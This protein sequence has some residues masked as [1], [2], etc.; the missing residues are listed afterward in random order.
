[1]ENKN[2]KDF[3]DKL[4]ILSKPLGALLTAFIIAGI[5][6]YG[7]NFLVKRQSEEMKIRLYTE[8]IS[9]REQAESSLRKDML[10]SII[11]SFLKPETASLEGKVLNLE[12]LA[13][14]F[15]E[16]LNLKP[17]FVHLK[18]QI[19]KDSSPDSADYMQ[20]VKKVAKEIKRKQ[21]AILEGA[22]DK[23]DINIRLEDVSS[24][25]GKVN[26]KVFCLQINNETHNEIRTYSRSFKV[27]VHSFDSIG[28]GIG[29]RLEVGPA[30]PDEC[31]EIVEETEIFEQS[32]NTLDEWEDSDEG[33]EIV[34]AE[35]T[36][37]VAQFWVDFF[38]F[39]MIDN[40]RLSYDQRCAVVLKEINEEDKILEIA[41]LYFPGSHASLKEKPYYD[42]IVNKLLSAGLDKNRNK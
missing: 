8:L 5:G 28:E 26:Q 14:N 7:N 41:V 13:Y 35:P 40:T 18:K 38:D 30:D 32:E 11:G 20:R 34:I 29:V 36:E 10:A 24:L 31:S 23:W 15:H 33:I 3:W 42:D 17:L 16:S 21:M 25:N 39:P 9:N 37:I 1:M 19:E 27:T 4:G 12:L 2:K 22:G 6:I